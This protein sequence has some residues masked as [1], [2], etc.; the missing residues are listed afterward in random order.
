VGGPPF[1]PSATFTG[2]RPGFV[3]KKGSSG[4]GYYRDGPGPSFGAAEE[5]IDIDEDEV[6]YIYLYINL[7]V[8][9]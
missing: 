9:N 2:A 8:Y 7:Y 4:V 6:R 5:E 1:T 3:F